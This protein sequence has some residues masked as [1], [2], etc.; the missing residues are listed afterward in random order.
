MENQSSVHYLSLNTIYIGRAASCRRS[1]PSSRERGI[2][3]HN[4]LSSS[5]SAPST[6]LLPLSESDFFFYFAARP[7][8]FFDAQTLDAIRHRAICF[9]LSAQ[10]ESLGKGNSVVFHSMVIAKRKEDS[11]KV[12][13]LLHWTPE[14]ILPD[15]WVNET[16]WHQLK[17]KVVHLSKLPSD[18]ALL[19]DPNIYRNPSKRMAHS[20]S[21][22]DHCF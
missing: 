12:K 8:D 6:V 21:L 3:S 15:A 7:H 20:G 2:N 16:E 19:L 22:K 1:Q 10:I 9:N 17:T 18:T 13:L 5:C 11:G 4:H 14:D